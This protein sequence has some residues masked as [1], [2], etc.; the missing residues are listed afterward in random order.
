MISGLPVLKK[1]VQCLRYGG[2]RLGD[3]GKS[4]VQ[5]DPTGKR[6]GHSAGARKPFTRGRDAVLNYGVCIM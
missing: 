2:A 5:Y 6:G 4:K 1:R 3:D